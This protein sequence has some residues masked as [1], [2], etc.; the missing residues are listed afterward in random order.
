MV[1]GLYLLDVVVKD[2]DN[3]LILYSGF[4]RE[5]QYEKHEL[6]KKYSISDYLEFQ[7]DW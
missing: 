5:A 4:I 6:I 1:Q 2:R 3:F 7:E